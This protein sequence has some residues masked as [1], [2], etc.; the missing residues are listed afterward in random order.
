MKQLI[1]IAL[2]IVSIASHAQ[3]V[4]DARRSGY[5][6]TKAPNRGKVTVD[7]S[8]EYVNLVTIHFNHTSA[9]CYNVMA[10]MTTSTGRV[11][12]I[13][14]CNKYSFGVIKAKEFPLNIEVKYLDI[15][16]VMRE[17]TLDLL[18]PGFYYRIDSFYD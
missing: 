12:T 3:D 8:L 16:S 11:K 13:D 4:Y 6:F 15:D 2:M 14:T 7:V 9:N 10:K 18:Y 5:K 1:I 17:F